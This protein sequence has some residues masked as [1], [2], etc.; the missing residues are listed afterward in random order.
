MVFCTLFCLTTFHSIRD[1]FVLDHVNCC[2]HFAFLSY[3]NRELFNK[4]GTNWA[5]MIHTYTTEVDPQL[6]GASDR[7]NTK[8]PT[9]K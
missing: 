1:L 2:H 9:K 5:F 3:S 7:Y 6:G 8:K 4:M